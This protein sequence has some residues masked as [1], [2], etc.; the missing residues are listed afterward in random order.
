MAEKN[1]NPRKRPERSCVACRTTSD[2]QA[3]IRFVRLVSGEVC[4][5][6]TGRQAGRGAYLCAN[7]QCFDQARKR[8][9][10]DRALKTKLSEAD[11]QRLEEAFIVQRCE[12]TRV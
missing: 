3:L 10:L 4:C 2:K 8:Q 9:Q 1:H 5:D 12:V 6:P 7:Q 11:Y